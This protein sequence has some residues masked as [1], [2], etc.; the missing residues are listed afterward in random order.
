MIESSSIAIPVWLEQEKPGAEILQRDER[1]QRN[2]KKCI[3]IF[4]ILIKI[5]TAIVMKG[6]DVSHEQVSGSVLIV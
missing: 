4:T 6:M 1:N 5:S 2:A 3:D